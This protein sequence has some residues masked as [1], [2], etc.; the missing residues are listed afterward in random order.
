MESSSG[1]CSAPPSG[2]QY[3]RPFGLSPKTLTYIV[4]PLLALTPAFVLFGI[5]AIWNLLGSFFGAYLRR[6]TEG[7]RAHI[8]GV[9]AEDEKQHAKKEGK[10]FTASGSGDGTVDGR[11]ALATSPANYIWQMN[12]SVSWD[13]FT[14]SGTLTG[15]RWRLEMDG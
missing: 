4:A 14:H 3:Y 10:K 7:R 12:G 1:S 11:L 8:L 13:S 2:G 6:K 9:I 15:G 5:P